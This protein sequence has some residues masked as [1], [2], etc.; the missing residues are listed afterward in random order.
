MKVLY[1]VMILIFGDGDK[2][3]ID[4]KFASI[5]ECSNSLRSIVRV[6]GDD[7]MA[8]SS[9]GLCIPIYGE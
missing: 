3:V 4:H 2:Q 9:K 1:V 6:N 7:Q 8:D 5:T